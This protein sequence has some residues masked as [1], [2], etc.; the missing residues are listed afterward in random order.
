M[1]LKWKNLTLTRVV[2]GSP[3]TVTPAIECM[4][5]INYNMTCNLILPCETSVCDMNITI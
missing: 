3:H 4:V 5:F 2:F 1:S